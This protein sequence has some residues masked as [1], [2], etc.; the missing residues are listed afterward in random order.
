MLTADFGEDTGDIGTINGDLTGFAANGQSEGWDVNFEQAMIQM[1]MM[2]DPNDQNPDDGVDMIVT[3]NLG[4]EVQRRRQRA[5]PGPW[6]DR[7]LERSVL[8]RHRRCR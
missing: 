2:V 8:R 5:C 3:P 7:I 1:G 6:L 4:P